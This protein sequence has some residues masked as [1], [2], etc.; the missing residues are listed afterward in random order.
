MRVR[1]A[2]SINLL[3]CITINSIVQWSYGDFSELH[4]I[5][6]FLSL[7]YNVENAIIHRG[8][9]LKCYR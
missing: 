4:C 6:I 9:E 7:L 5:E 2:V 1:S 3:H 8:G